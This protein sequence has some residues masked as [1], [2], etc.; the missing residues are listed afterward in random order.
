VAG[1]R[2]RKYVEGTMS[3]QRGQTGTMAV[4]YRVP[5][6]AEVVSSDSL[7][8]RLSVDPQD[9]VVPERLQVRVTWPAGFHPSTGLPRGWKPTKDGATYSGRVSVQDLWEIPLARG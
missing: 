4:R 1:V 5:K 2:N 3:L 9:L 6:A 7:V 8:Y